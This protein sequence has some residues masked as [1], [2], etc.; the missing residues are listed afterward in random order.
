L[1]HPWRV[2][3]FKLSNWTN[4]RSHY[5][6]FYRESK[7]GLREIVFHE[8]RHTWQLTAKSRSIAA[9]GPDIDTD[10]DGVFIPG[11]LPP[12]SADLFDDNNMN[13]PQGI[14]GT[15]GT[16]GDGHFIGEILAGQDDPEAVTTVREH[17]AI[18]F[19]NRLGLLSKFSCTYQEIK[20][21]SHTPDPVSGAVS[22]VGTPGDVL[23]VEVS[24]MWKHLGG[25]AGN[26]VQGAG[27][28]LQFSVPDGCDAK[29]DNSDEAW[30]MTV[31]K[32]PASAKVDIKIGTTECTVVAE[33]VAP[34]SPPAPPS[35]APINFLVKPQ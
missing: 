28:T 17:N 10:N 4:S 6:G 26:V 19:T 15:G 23:T 33:L 20:V 7:D 21:L 9:N 5:H 11:S 27:A 30:V 13:D 18:R 24:L 16:S 1:L 25:Q 31:G 32:N 8:A 2:S 35:V 22:L 12:S 29:V 3:R 34:M 14:S